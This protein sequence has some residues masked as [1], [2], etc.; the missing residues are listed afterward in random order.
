MITLSKKATK[1]HSNRLSYL[2]IWYNNAIKNNNV[3]AAKTAMHHYNRLK[4]VE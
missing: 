1:I 3:W 2:M 4:R